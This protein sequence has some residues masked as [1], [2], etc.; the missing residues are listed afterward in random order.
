MRRKSPTARIDM[1]MDLRELRRTLLRGCDGRLP[2]CNGDES[3][4]PRRMGVVEELLSRSMAAPRVGCELARSTCGDD[5]SPFAPAPGDRGDPVRRPN[6]AAAL[7]RLTGGGADPR[8]P[9]PG[10]PPRLY[11]GDRSL[12][13][14][15]VVRGLV[16]L[17]SALGDNATDA[18]P[19]SAL[20]AVAAAERDAVELAGA[21]LFKEA[22]NDCGVAALVLWLPSSLSRAALSA[23]AS[24]GQ[25]IGRSFARGDALR[26]R[27]S[28]GHCF[29]APL[30]PLA[31]PAPPVG[32]SVNF[33]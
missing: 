11:L 6:A 5:L 1:R 24:D 32:L 17:S 10:L 28:E 16:L 12:S 25:C 23:A 18:T 3:D 15:V 31:P 8:R 22:A 14:G 33:N 2:R 26:M 27:A 20:P 9:A 7:L 19:P 13:S 29:V 30:V 21:S 4:T